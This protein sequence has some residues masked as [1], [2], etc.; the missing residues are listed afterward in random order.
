[1][2][3]LIT[4][5]VILITLL[6]LSLPYIKSNLSDIDPEAL[7]NQAS[8][9]PTRKPNESAIY[10]SVDVP[11]G[12]PLNTGLRIRHGGYKV[13]DGCLKDVWLGCLQTILT[14][15]KSLKSEK[16]QKELKKLKANQKN[17]KTN[18]GIMKVDDGS[19]A[20]A[21]RLKIQEFELKASGTK[22]KIG[23]SSFTILQLN[24]IMK[25][26]SQ[27]LSMSESDDKNE[28][29]GLFTDFS[30]LHSLIVLLTFFF[31]YDGS[32][33]NLTHMPKSDSD[34]KIGTV[35][36]DFNQ[37]LK[38][39]NSKLNGVRRIVVFEAPVEETPDDV[40]DESDEEE[41]KPEEPQPITLAEIEGIEIVWFS[42]FF[43]YDKVQE[44]ETF[45]YDQSLIDDSQFNNQP[46]S[47]INSKGEEIRFF[48][49]NFVS[50]I[51]SQ[52]MS[53]NSNFRWNQGD[54]VLIGVSNTKQSKNNLVLKTLCGV[55]ACVRE[56][57]IIDESELTL[58]KLTANGGLYANSSIIQLYWYIHLVCPAC[59]F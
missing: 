50:S 29:F 48:Q 56:I 49:R 4:I 20:E 34:L 42:D 36:V 41:T 40:T 9:S 35:F 46:Y 58:K 31:W 26:L 23:D 11:H 39:A 10:R 45:D 32:I 13:R 14:N 30:D 21:E 25:Q 38:V 33:V 44:L 59:T 47:E 54:K 12:V 15:R 1:M 3:Y 28:K 24:W 43:K 52:L 5:S 37:Y 2:P 16:N 51:A 55:L 18:P 27:V 17:R 8:I 6:V 7:Q 22:F 57:E 19:R 53:V